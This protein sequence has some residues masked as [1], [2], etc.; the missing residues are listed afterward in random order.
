M[1]STVKELHVEIEQRIQQITSNRRRSIAPEF[2][3]MVLNRAALSLIDERLSNKTNLKR[4]GFDE[5]SIRVD[6][7]QSLKRSLTIPIKGYVRYNDELLVNPYGYANIPGNYYRYIKATAYGCYFKQPHKFLTHSY[8]NVYAELDVNKLIELKGQGKIEL[9]ITLSTTLRYNLTDVVNSY[10]PTFGLFN[11]SNDLKTFFDLNDISAYWEY[12]PLGND[13]GYINTPT[14]LYAPNCFLILGT[15]DYGELLSTSKIKLFV[16]G[17]EQ[18]I[19]T[20]RKLWKGYRFSYAG[21]DLVT[22]FEAKV[23]LV[24]SEDVNDLLDNTYTNKRRY[25][26][27]LAV[28]ENNRLKVFNSTEHMRFFVDRIA[29][30]YIK[31]PVP[32]NIR[33]GQMSD[34]TVS[35]DLIK[36]AVTDILLM[37]KDGSYQNVQQQING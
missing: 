8:D 25:E 6:D 9:E 28:L 17:I 3:D 13:Y 36:K 29:L 4:E 11:I 21:D 37:L 20:I 34:I 23:N 35:N 16:N 31:I 19:L 33:T 10:N 27:P 2:I 18:N 12:A 32:F 26:N 24:S 5:S 30:E 1:Y 15:Y 22:P 7:L 14:S